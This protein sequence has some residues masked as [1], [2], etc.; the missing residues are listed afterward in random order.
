MAG[1]G[2]VV[3]TGIDGGVAVVGSTLGGAAIGCTAV[4]GA[5]VEMGGG[6]KLPVGKLGLLGGRLGAP[7]GLGLE[8]FCGWETLF[9]TGGLWRIV[10]LGDAYLMVEHSVGE[11]G[12][13]AGWVGL[14]WD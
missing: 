2:S 13:G 9:G 14:G 10:D 4:T 12:V 3:G 8:V 5:A 6:V 1:P 7:T 11:N